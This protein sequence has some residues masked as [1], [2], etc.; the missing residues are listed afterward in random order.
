MTAKSDHWERERRLLQGAVALGGFVP[1]GAGLGGVLLGPAFVGDAAGVDGDS[2]FR[3]LSGLLL[4]IGLIFWASIPAIETR[5]RRVRLLTLVVFV[6]GLGRLLS[7]F[8][9]GS[10]SGPM[11]FGLAMELVITP[12]IC[13]WQGRI[14]RAFAGAS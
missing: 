12:A 5:T 6:G 8:L 4:G 10:P 1:V 14:A 9:L 13:L 7:L 2:H 3:Y 11:L